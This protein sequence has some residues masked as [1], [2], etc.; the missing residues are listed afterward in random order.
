MIHVVQEVVMY[1][2]ANFDAIIMMNLVS[3]EYL[4]FKYQFSGSNIQKTEGKKKTLQNLNL[5]QKLR[6][7]EIYK[8]HLVL[9]NT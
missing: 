2:L 3:V 6:L 9:F 5:K 4:R 8:H 7:I 1:V